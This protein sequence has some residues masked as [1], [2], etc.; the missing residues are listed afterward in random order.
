MAAAAGQPSSPED[1]ART[2]LAMEELEDAI[3]RAREECFGDGAAL[4]QVQA[5]RVL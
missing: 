3:G 4:P 1:H 5:H 2:M